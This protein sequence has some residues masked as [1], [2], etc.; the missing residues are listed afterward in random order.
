MT[1]V[2]L[3]NMPRLSLGD[4]LRRRKM[5]LKQFIGE[6]GITTY[7]SLNSLCDRMG[8]APPSVEEFDAICA[9]IKHVVNS[10]QEGI[11]VLEPPPV[12]V[13][14]DVPVLDE[15]IVV[16]SVDKSY[17]LYGEMPSVGPQKKFRRNKD[18]SPSE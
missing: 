11:I 6:F 4:V 5:T 1:K 15:S 2:K 18:K 14:V 9:P 17:D 8:C 12:S 16:D 13:V 3:R 10:P 7:V